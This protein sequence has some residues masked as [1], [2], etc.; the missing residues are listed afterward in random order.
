MLG[1]EAT[2]CVVALEL[3]SGLRGRS[4]EE[5]AVAD[6]VVE[7]GRAAA[8]DAARCPRGRARRSDARDR[9]LD[10]NGTMFDAAGRSV[11]IP[12]ETPARTVTTIKRGG[13][14][15]A[16]VIHDPAVLDDPTLVEAIGAA[17]RLEAANSRLRAS[18]RAQ[19]AELEA[20]R[21][22]LLAARDGER[23]RLAARLHEGAER[24]L[25]ILASFLRD[26]RDRAGGGAAADHV[27][28]AQVQLERTL[29]DL[30][31][32]AGGLHP[33]VL[34][35]EGLNGGI[36]DL[37]VACPVSVELDLEDAA[38]TGPLAGRRL[39]RMGAGLLEGL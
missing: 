4:R 16:A 21:R 39:F 1:Y 25:E 10:E 26:A 2:I 19:L 7:L 32:L 23:Q 34:V 11:V 24:H 9:L 37:A 29:A 35:E 13:E 15:V 17:A 28:R 8:R 12:S 38:M 20:S 27:E 18:F 31:A 14:R 33:R 22:R 36:R 5:A 3:L 6:L 30:Y